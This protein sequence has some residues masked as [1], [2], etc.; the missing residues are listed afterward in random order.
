MKELKPPAQYMEALRADCVSRFST[1]LHELRQ[2]CS[3]TG[4]D[5]GKIAG[6]KMKSHD[7]IETACVSTAG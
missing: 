7:V 3:P 4:K 1:D 6:I 5:A 2:D